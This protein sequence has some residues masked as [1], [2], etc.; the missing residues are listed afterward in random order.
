MSLKF[1]RLNASNEENTDDKEI[2]K[3]LVTSQLKYVEITA[4]NMGIRNNISE[5]MKT[6]TIKMT[7]HSIKVV[8]V[9][10]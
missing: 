4:E 10:I 7:T 3:A 5:S 8:L 6:T 1:E 2:E 9:K